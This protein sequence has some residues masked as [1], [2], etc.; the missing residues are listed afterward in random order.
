M[1]V[2]INEMLSLTAR[3]PLNRWANDR[4]QPGSVGSVGDANM[5]VRYKQNMPDAEMRF[6]PGTSGK[7]LSRLGSI[8][9]DGDMNDGD[10]TRVNDDFF[11][12]ERNDRVAN[13]WRFQDLRIPDTEM[14]PIQGG[15]P[16]Y[17]WRN[18]I[19]TV[20]DAKRTGEGFLPLPGPFQLGPGQTAR[21]GSMPRTVAIQGDETDVFARPA[22]SSL[23]DTD[24][25]MSNAG[26]PTGRAFGTAGRSSIPSFLLD[27]RLS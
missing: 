25:T 5:R 13:G 1:Y 10:M 24:P 12:G 3:K 8:L 18:R 16:Q 21:G 11:G 22:I 2:L 14:E 26:R 19:A 17:S 27:R 6:E 7:A 20:F 15:T 4:I 9:T 23:V